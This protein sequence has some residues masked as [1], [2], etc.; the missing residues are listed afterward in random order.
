MDFGEALKI[1][2]E[3]GMIYRTGWN[4]IGLFVFAQVPAI[5]GIDIIPKM[6]SLPNQ[7]K[8][9]F[10]NRAEYGKPATFQSIAYKDQLALVDAFNV[11]TGW[12]PSTADALATDW[13]V[14]V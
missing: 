9:V 5:I 3:G 8:D 10:I 13:K 1:V 14:Y 2:K 11:I 4:G 7:V 6:Q 12:S